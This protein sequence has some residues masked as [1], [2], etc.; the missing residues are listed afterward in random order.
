MPKRLSES[1]KW[2]D[3]WFMALSPQSKLLWEYVRD[4]CDLTG[5]YEVNL[6]L[7]RFQTKFS[8]KVDL[9]KHLH[10]FN[11]VSKKLK[12]SNR[13]EWFADEKALWIVNFV[14]IQYGFLS[15]NVSTHRGVIKV[16]EMNLLKKGL[17]K[18]YQTLKDKIK[19]KDQNEGKRG[20]GKKPFEPPKEME[21]LEVMRLRCD[22]SV[23]ANFESKQFINF[24]ESKGWKV[25]DQPMQNWRAS[26]Q[27]WIDE[28][29]QEAKTKF[30]GNVIP[31]QTKISEFQL[32]REKH[33]EK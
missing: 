32:A 26:A 25:G 13:V 28:Q 2:C 16:L 27:K 15:E 18:G 4:N 21:V 11:E 17:P 10:E 5:V 29:M 12:M 7:M 8:E 14:K 24:Y 9:M 22:H 31:L 33:K 20:V 3:V 23:D 30:S 19:N 1:N 6:D